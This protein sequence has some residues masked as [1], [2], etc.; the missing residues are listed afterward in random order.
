MTLIGFKASNHP[1]QVGRRGRDDSVDDRRTP[2]DLLS[3]CARIA[4]VSHFD[5]DVA[6]SADNAK[7]ERFFTIDD[8][9]LTQPWFGFVWC[10]PP[11][12]DIAAW[13]EKADQERDNP[14][15]S[16]TVML[17]PANRTEQW[18]WHQWIERYRESGVE[19]H[20]LAGRRRFDRP[21]WTKPAKGDR[22][23]FGLCV[24]VFRP[25]RKV[26]P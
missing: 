10:N 2:P 5:L 9:G 13:V 14:R 16:A 6:A 11:Y 4:Y 26:N 20:F 22:P 19:V 18:W 25:R 17:L 12:S 24:V 1:Q 3:E 15:V 23:P 7:A 8:D 21:G